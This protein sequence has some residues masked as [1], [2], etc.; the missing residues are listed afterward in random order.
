M[1]DMT[2]NVSSA[3]TAAN[4]NRTNRI[5]NYESIFKDYPDVVTV[6]HVQEML[7]IGRN[8]AYSLLKDGTLKAFKNG[9][10]YIIPKASV[11]NFVLGIVA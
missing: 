1:T 11:V 2:M 6:D 9:T 3:N 10:H 7:H 8:T 4:E 5:F